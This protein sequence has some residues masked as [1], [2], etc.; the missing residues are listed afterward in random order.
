MWRYERV[1]AM[2]PNMQEQLSLTSA[3]TEKL[4]DLKTAYQKKEVDMQALR[5]KRQLK[6][7]S[8]LQNNA[9]P[10]VVRKQLQSCT[11]VG[12]NIGID[13]YKTVQQMEMVLNDSQ[14]KEF[15]GWMM[16]SMQYGNMYNSRMRRGMMNNY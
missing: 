6:L 12:I 5:Q 2:L 13:A 1:V 9:S 11:D 14:Q 3:Q 7:Q 15:Q 10:E 4:I 8:L 16:K